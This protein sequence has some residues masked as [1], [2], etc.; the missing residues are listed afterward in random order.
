MGVSNSKNK[1]DPLNDCCCDIKLVIIASKTLEQVLEEHFEASGRGLHEKI[2]S[3]QGLPGD[4]KR[5]MRRVATVRNKLIHQIGFDH[6]DADFKKDFKHCH[7]ELKAILEARA[8][9][10]GGTKRCIVS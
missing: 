1:S 10:E 9:T 8:A 6:V 7:Q 2:T 4:L 3:A 5:K